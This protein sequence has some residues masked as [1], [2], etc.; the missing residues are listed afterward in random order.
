MY[1]GGGGGIEEVGLIEDLRCKP[2][3]VRRY[4]LTTIRW[5]YYDIG[6]NIELVMSPLWFAVI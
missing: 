4:K 2:C 5:G 1:G 6:I 3:S